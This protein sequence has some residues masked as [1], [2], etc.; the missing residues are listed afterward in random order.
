MDGAQLLHACGSKLHRPPHLPAHLSLRLRVHPAAHDHARRPHHR[1]EWPRDHIRRH[2]P[3]LRLDHLRVRRPRGEWLRLARATAPVPRAA[4]GARPLPPLR[5]GRVGVAGGRPRG[6]PR[7][8]A[9]L[10]PGAAARPHRLQHGARGQVEGGHRGP[11]RRWQV[12]SHPRPLPLGRVGEWDRRDRWH[13]R[14]E[15]RHPGTSESHHDHP[16]GPG[17]A[18][19]NGG[20]QPRPLRAGKQANAP[21][22]LAAR[23][24]SR[25]QD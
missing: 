21:R 13:R 8:V 18:P 1:D 9:A 11:H 4:A 20:P 16:A 24:A 12:D 17:A 15:R 5:P 25:R 6:I 23:S 7:L 3:L 2:R 14:G 10:P 22:R 19:R